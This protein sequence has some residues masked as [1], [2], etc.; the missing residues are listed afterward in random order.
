VLNEKVSE[1]SLKV[2]A[3]VL[4][5]IPSYT[6]SNDRFATKPVV[7][8]FDFATN[9]SEGKSIMA[10]LMQASVIPQLY[11]I[12]MP[13]IVSVDLDSLRKTAS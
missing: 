9:V 13:W 11:S 10:T 8:M 12:A 4:L 6:P 1:D 7:G 3:R 5:G 2:S